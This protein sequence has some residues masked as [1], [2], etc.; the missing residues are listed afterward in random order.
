MAKLKSN[1]IEKADVEEY[2]RNTSDFD[3]ELKVLKKLSSL[4][5]TCQHTGL[6]EDPVTGKS[7]HLSV[8]CKNFRNNAPL[9]AYC[10]PRVKQ[11]SFHDVMVVRPSN[12]QDPVRAS[13]NA[14][15]PVRIVEMSEGQSL[16][17]VNRRVAKS[18]DQV[19]RK[20]DGEFLNNDESVHDKVSQALH[21][22]WN[23]LHSIGID[24][25]EN[26]AHV[27]LPVLVI[28]DDRLWEITYD[29]EGTQHGD[30]KNVERAEY[31]VNQVW[32]I[33]KSKAWNFRY[34]LSHLEIV[35]LSYLHDFIANDLDK[36]ND[37]AACFPDNVESV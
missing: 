1:P 18:I 14:I 7:R 36:A 31:W 17:P 25:R 4:G 8:E 34:H 29:A 12:H 35:A 9:L 3:F 2:V 13:V 27:V 15:A 22:S 20:L 5:F 6:Y 32:N 24:S 37:F 16:Y 19:A 10:V 11:E 33:E 21:S 26:K 28:P 30:I 23:I